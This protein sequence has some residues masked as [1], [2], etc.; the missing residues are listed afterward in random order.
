[1]T[2]DERLVLEGHL[3]GRRPWFGD[4]L[5]HQMLARDPELLFLGVARHLDDLHAV[6]QRRAESCR[7]RWPS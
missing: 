3:G 6:A 2:A 1:M 7:A 5:G 4:L